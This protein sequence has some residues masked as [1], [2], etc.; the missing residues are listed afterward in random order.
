MVLTRNEKGVFMEEM[1]QL[2]DSHRSVGVLNMENVP[3]S[4]LLMAKQDLASKVKIKMGRKTLIS[5]A[6]DDSKKDVKEIKSV[7]EGSIAIV[8]SND[9]AFDL[10][11]E[12][13][14]TKIKAAAKEGDVAKTD[15]I[16]P[17]GPTQIPPG[18]GISTLQKAGIKAQVQGGKLA[19]MNDTTV[20]KAGATVTPDI[21]AAL[22]LLGIMPNEKSLNITAIWEEN[23][24]YPASVLD[25]N[26]DRFMSD[27]QLCIMSTINLSL[28]SGY[29]VKESAPLAVQKAFLEARS[30]GI[31]AGILTKDTA[32]FIIGKAVRTAKAI[33]SVMPKTTEQQVSNEEGN[34][35]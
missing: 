12:L 6:I 33:E 3:A 29:L 15:I 13:M 17:K 18:P 8:F 27:L 24:V 22:N 25:I 34:A 26:M 21:V 19:L 23:V 14:S 30:L 28:N 16:V 31:E 35:L 32:E 4:L 5:M 20:L 11:K 2:I 7:M 1:K 9:N 10:F